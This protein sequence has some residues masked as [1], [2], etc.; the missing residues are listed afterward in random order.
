MQMVIDRHGIKIIPQSKQDEAYI[1]DTLSLKKG[2]DSI[3]LVRENVIGFHS[4]AQLNT[5]PFP[6]KKEV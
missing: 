3:L 5:H 4:L 2:G 6:T 1:E